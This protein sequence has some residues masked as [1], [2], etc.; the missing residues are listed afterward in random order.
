MAILS[1]SVPPLVNT[2]SLG[3]APMAAATFFPG[4]LHLFAGLAAKIVQAGGV[5][6]IPLE[7]SAH[8]IGYI[9]ANRR[10]GAV[11]EINSTHVHNLLWYYYSST[12]IYKLFSLLRNNLYL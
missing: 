8:F 1:D 10:C 7:E 11:V 5:A 9:R 4:G 3:V 2:I 12:T 6:K